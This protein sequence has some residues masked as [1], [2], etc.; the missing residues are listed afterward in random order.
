MTKHYRLWRLLALPLLSISAILPASAA[1]ISSFP[2][3]ETN[4]SSSGWTTYKESGGSWTIKSGDSCEAKVISGDSKAW[5]FSP[6][7]EVKSGYKYQF[8]FSWEATN[9][10]YAVEKLATYIL[11]AASYTA[12]KL[13]TFDAVE[14]SSTN[15]KVT[16]SY[17][18]IPD[19]DGTV[20]FAAY[21]LSNGSTG[22]YGSFA[23][24]KIEEAANIRQ[25]KPVSD[26]AYSVPSDEST[27]VTL[28]WT[29]PTT[30]NF[31][32]AMT[33]AS[34]KIT[35]N[36][37][38]VYT[39]T[40]TQYTTAGAVSYTDPTPG[41]GL[42]T[43]TV[44]V[45]DTQGAE[46]QAATLNTA[47]IGPFTG[48]TLPYAYTI[49]GNPFNALWSLT[50]NGAS[51]EWALDEANECLSVSVSNSNP[52]DATAT[53]PAF[54]FDNDKAYRI[55][56][57][58]KTS[59]KSNVI[60]LGAT[61]TGTAGT[62]EL[63]P[64]AACEPASNNSYETASYV[65]T[66]SAA[67]K[68]SL[69]WHATAE[70][71]T[72]SYYNNTLSISGIE[73]EVL[74]T[75]PL[76]ATDLTAKAAAD[77]SRSVALTWKNPTTNETGL[78]VSNLEAKI[79]RNGQLAATVA[80]SGEDGSYTDTPATDGYFTY[81]V[82]ISNENGASEQ[83]AAQA[84]SDYVGQPLEM[85][86]TAD[87][88]N[89][90]QNWIGMES[91]EYANGNLFTINTDQG[92][93]VVTETD[94]E[95]ADQLVS[96]PINLKAGKSYEISVLSSL[97]SSSMGYNVYITKDLNQLGEPLSQSFSASSY[98]STPTKADFFV[99]EDG[100]YAI[101]I[102]PKR[103]TSSYSYT[104]S[105]YVK[106]VEMTEI[107]TVPAAVADL[108]ALS[109]D[110]DKKIDVTFT[111]PSQSTLGMA[112]TG[113]LKASIYREKTI[114]SESEA[115]K[116]ITAAA[117]EAVSWRDED[118]DA[119][120][121][122]DYTVTVALDETDATASEAASVTSD[123]CGFAYATPYMPDFTVEADRNDWTIADQSGQ[124]TAY[125]F[126]WN[127]ANQTFFIDEGRSHT[128]SYSYLDDWLIS[129]ALL[130]NMD[131][132]FT[133]TMEVKSNVS[134]STYSNYNTHYYIY[135]G[136]T[137]TPADF[138]NK[139][140]EITGGSARL[141]QEAAT[142]GFSTYTHTYTFKTDSSSQS[143]APR[144]EDVNSDPEDTDVVAKKFVAVRFG[145]KYQ[146]NYPYV[147][148]K[149]IKVDTNINTG[150]GTIGRDNANT[151]LYM[152]STVSAADN[153]EILVY[154]MDGTIVAKGRG[155][156]ST[157]SL[158]EGVYV[159][160]SGRSTMKIVR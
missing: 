71:M 78:P 125:Q 116:E 158:Q 58:Y 12:D 149:S 23:D 83:P 138:V 99:A 155:S 131:A 107:K 112:L 50:T 86:F 117:G 61:L 145:Q 76:P 153:A 65:L 40:D 126:E 45:T 34:V 75:I 119:N 3:E 14:T 44:V 81:K 39:L 29:N 120:G 13:A 25:P 8:S 122:Y 105:F 93:A 51:N 42:M 141:D 69:S 17:E 19:A 134:T 73:I 24:F 137:N 4:F 156:I 49:N 111:M 38:T 159:V 33:I 57:K 9:T 62:V 37:G 7:I 91:G 82:E 124:S 74:P 22:Y 28:T 11:S 106:S 142:D 87:F 97:S 109:V 63:M 20:Y 79:Y 110:M 96:A 55:T 68:Y 36:D 47:Y 59:N 66:P 118:I 108:K 77:G 135:F 150:I 31:G 89:E 15:T 127:E 41:A 52:I 60:N 98:S 144:K 10:R 43:Y 54:C 146:S 46:S 101:V 1:T 48:I 5:L 16:A 95:F 18:Y 35:R 113:N 136:D 121:F 32:D 85:P 84:V 27:A 154:S 132:E 128:S 56:F 80:T 160:R 152:G 6:A 26:L 147:E 157:A 148:V 21:D 2:Y 53:T 133:L 129:P 92:W 72:A 64:A 90:P 115:V 100:A 151:L 130:F 103:S 139:G 70:Q 104:R 102:E 67:G 140:V 114:T 143:V 30:D 94:T 88:K 123:W